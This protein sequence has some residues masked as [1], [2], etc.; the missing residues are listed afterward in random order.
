MEHTEA[1]EQ[2]AVERYLLDEMNPAVRTAFEEHLFDCAEC[3]LD[4]R[5]SSFF[6]DEAKVQLPGLPRSTPAR[7]QLAKR[8]MADRWFGWMRPAFAVP[9]FAA[10]LGV[11]AFQNAVTLPHLREAATEPR[12]VPFTHLRPATR[13]ASHIAL[14]VDRKLGAAVQVDLPA[15][16]TVESPVAYSVQLLDGQQKA[17]WSTR[18]AAEGAKA[19]QDQQLT[20]ILP[21]TQLASGSYTLTV[22]ALDGQGHSTPVE[23]YLFDIVVTN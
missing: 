2:L 15:G 7:D 18:V 4:V 22:A 14:T 8:S 20:M 3:A 16:A 12:V 5:A 13:G 23:Q 9:A 21:G 19:D 1:V 6:I 10:L 11:V 17:I